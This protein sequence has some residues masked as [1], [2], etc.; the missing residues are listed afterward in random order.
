MSTF[1][2]RLVFKNCKNQRTLLYKYPPPPHTILLLLKTDLIDK[3]GGPKFANRGPQI[4]HRQWHHKVPRG[5]GGGGGIT[6]GYL[7][8]KHGRVCSFKST[9][10]T[11]IQ[12]WVSFMNTYIEIRSRVFLR[13]GFNLPTLKIAFFMR[14]ILHQKCIILGLSMSMY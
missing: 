13:V 11:V 7:G 3:R 14:S 5:G 9:L 8:F 4:A 12:S 6:N 10:S 1:L 2:K